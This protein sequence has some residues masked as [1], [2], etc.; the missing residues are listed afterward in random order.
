MP[1]CA[2]FSPPGPGFPLCQGVFF[3]AFIFSILWWGWCCLLVPPSPQEGEMH[4]GMGTS[5]RAGGALA[6]LVL[7]NKIPGEQGAGG[8]QHRLQVQGHARARVGASQTSCACTHVCLC[9]RTCS[10]SAGLVQDKVSPTVQ[11]A[12][13][14]HEHI[15]GGSLCLPPA[16]PQGVAGQDRH[17]FSWGKKN[18]TSLNDTRNDLKHRAETQLSIKK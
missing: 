11:G 4:S 10:R 6:A 9:T 1:Q 15:L 8:G 5:R 17:G 18:L 16:P 14:V 3:R 7:S 13:R 2:W 12:G